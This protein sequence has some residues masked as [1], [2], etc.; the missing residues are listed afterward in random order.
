MKHLRHLVVAV[1]VP[2]LILGVFTVSAVFAGGPQ[3]KSDVCHHAAHKYVEI[4]VSNNAVPAHLA[5]GDV[6]PDEY[7][8]CPS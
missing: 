5:H 3:G 8:D 7:G 6:L 1:V 2:A 4:N